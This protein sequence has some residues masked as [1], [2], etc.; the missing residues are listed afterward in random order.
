MTA[1]L[2]S[3]SRPPFLSSTRQAVSSEALVPVKCEESA[4]FAAACLWF[5]L[6][7]AAF[8]MDLSRAGEV[9]VSKISIFWSSK[10]LEKGGPGPLYPVQRGLSHFASGL[11]VAI[12]P[13]PRLFARQAGRGLSRTGC[14]LQSRLAGAWL[15][16][17][18]LCSTSR[19]VL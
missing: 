11:V 16:A 5:V 18:P 12:C 3:E 2:R 8:S 15:R 17:T 10:K 13:P 4:S 6:H 9:A 7:T 14:A 1:A 19:W